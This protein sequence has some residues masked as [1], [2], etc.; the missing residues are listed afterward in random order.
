MFIGLNVENFNTQDLMYIKDK[1]EKMDDEKFFMIQGAEFQK[2]LNIFLI[3]IL[4]G[5]ERFFLEDI[6]M[7]LVKILTFGG[8]GIWYLIDIFSAKDRAK[9]YNF[10]KFIKVTSFM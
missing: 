1:L 10:N 2:P 6:A 4:L 7:G 5:W 9:A 3:A 8:C